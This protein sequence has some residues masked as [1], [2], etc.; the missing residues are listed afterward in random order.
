MFQ[1]SNILRRRLK[2]ST[3]HYF[4]RRMKRRPCKAVRGYEFELGT[5][6]PPVVLVYAHT[7]FILV[8]SI[9]KL[10]YTWRIS[11]FVLH[12]IQLYTVKLILGMYAHFC[13]LT[14]HTYVAYKCMHARIVLVVRPV[15]ISI[16]KF[17]YIVSLSLFFSFSTIL[18]SL[19]IK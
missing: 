19:V 5:D 10:T 1:S 14:D 4:P 15:I 6:V 2:R 16:Y 9:T 7:H 18:Q 12:T 11:I 8:E 13:T 3:R 17:T